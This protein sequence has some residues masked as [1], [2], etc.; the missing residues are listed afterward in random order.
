MKR[1]WAEQRTD[2]YTI[3]L[4]D[5][6]LEDA[7]PYILWL[8]SQK[9]CAKKATGGS[10]DPEEPDDQQELGKVLIKA[11]LYSLKVMDDVYR[12]MII[13][14]LFLLHD[15]YD[16]IPQPDA[17]QMLYDATS[18]GDSVRRLMQDFLAH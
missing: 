5:D 2:P 14:R 12:K 3:D 10:F 7:T 17:L 4:E 8:K 1:E 18:L 13:R 11:Y 16:W 15:T 9:I 6:C